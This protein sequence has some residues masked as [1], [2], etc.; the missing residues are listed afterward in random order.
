MSTVT[1]AR[2]NLKE[3]TIELEGSEAFV[4]KYLDAFREHMMEFEFEPETETGET[5]AQAEGRRRRKRVGKT[6]KIVAPI[7]LDLKA[8][9]DRPSLRDFCKEKAPATHMERVTVFAYY[10]D[11]HLNIREMQSGHVV[12]CCKE[13]S[14]RIPT[15]IPQMF[16]N[17]QQLHGW[18]KV[19]KA[20]Q[21][22]TIT[23]QGINLVEQDLPR[24]KNVRASKTTT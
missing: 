15:D 14:C 2:I 3:G 1:K 8:K 7:P 6:P 5:G 23:T 17:I 10:L 12:S 19:G 13:V 22:A 20:G 21:V 9:D 16:Y 24:K 4:S 18:I 11:K